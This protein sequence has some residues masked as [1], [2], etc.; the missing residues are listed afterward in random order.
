MLDTA[1]RLSGIVLMAGAALL[2]IAIVMISITP[3]I[4]QPLPPRLSLLFLFSA[5][6]LLLSLPAMYARQAEAAGWLGLIG[7]ALLQTGLLLLVLLAAP[8]LLYPSLNPAL[9]EN[10]VVFVLGIALTLGLLLTGIAMI[11]AGVYPRGAAILLLMATVGFFF[12]FFV[13]EF[14]P[15]LAGQ[16]RAAFFGVLLALAFIWVG[17]ALWM[18]KPTLAL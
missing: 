18:S 5:T 7:H 16:I 3:V 12:D 4:N 14:L 15:P 10:L 8:P 13:A 6:M 9:E 17:G 1:L 11:Q 2:G